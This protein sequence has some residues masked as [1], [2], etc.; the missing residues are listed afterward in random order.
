MV[1]LGTCCGQAE[2]GNLI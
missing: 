1:I 2:L